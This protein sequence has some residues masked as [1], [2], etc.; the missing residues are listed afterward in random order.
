MN[1]LAVSLGTRR[2][3]VAVLQGN[4]LTEWETQPP[5]KDT[6]FGIAVRVQNDAR[7]ERGSEES[8]QISPYG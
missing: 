3:G 7:N 8:C 4:E 1:I 2:T 6:K 5:A